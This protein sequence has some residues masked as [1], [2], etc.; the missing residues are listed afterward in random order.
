VSEYLK[1]AGAE[2][3]VKFIHAP[4]VRVA[5]GNFECD[6]FDVKIL[7]EKLFN[8]NFDLVLVDAPVSSSTCPLIRMPAG[9]FIKDYLTEDFS[10]FL[11]DIDRPGEQVIAKKWC[12][13]FG[14]KISNYWPAGGVASF[15][16][17][18]SSSFN[19][20]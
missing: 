17:R 3:N 15:T 20:C 18:N 12:S 4:I 1:E 11:D 16:P 6:W 7:N 19:L 13:M 2:S 14:W 10:I 9:N 8:M 5:G